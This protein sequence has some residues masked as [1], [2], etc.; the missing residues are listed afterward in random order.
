[1]GNLRDEIALPTVEGRLALPVEEDDVHPHEDGHE[2]RQPFRQ[3]QPVEGV[4]GQQVRL[5]LF[6][7]SPELL[8]TTD[9]PV[10]P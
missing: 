5:V 8:V 4:A 3:D 6:R 9:E 7:Q 1:M 10:D 2:K